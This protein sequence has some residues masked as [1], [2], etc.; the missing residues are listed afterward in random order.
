[1]NKKNSQL[2]SIIIIGSVLIFVIILYLFAAPAITNYQNV[3][4]K[5]LNETNEVVKLEEQ[6]NE[7]KEK[8]KQEDIQIQSL[9]QIYL[10]EN[11]NTDENLGKFGTMFDDII[12]RAQYNGLLIRSIEYDMKPANSTIYNTFSDTYNVCELK[13]FFVAT[14]SQLKTFLNELTNSFPYLISISNLDVTA[15]SGNEDYL[16]IKMSITLYSKKQV[17]EE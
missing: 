13:F 5:I 8:Q 3:K 7:E 16:L 6:Y 9:K 4:T 15:F 10:T 17:K 12:K 1:M 11:V 14:Y 2:V